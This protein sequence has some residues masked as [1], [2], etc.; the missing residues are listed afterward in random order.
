MGL[1]FTDDNDENDSND[2]NEKSIH[3]ITADY[4]KVGGNIHT[5]VFKRQLP[6]LK[7]LTKANCLFLK[8]LGYD[9]IKSSNS[10]F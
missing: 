9:V 6:K 3:Q 1:V 7:A 8:S 10:Y 5:S 4:K 2:S